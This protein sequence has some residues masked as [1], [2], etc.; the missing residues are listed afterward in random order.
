MGKKKFVQ[1]NHDADNP[2]GLSSSLVYTM[3]EDQEG[4]LWVGSD[5]LNR[6]DSETEKNTIFSYNPN[7]PNSLAGEHIYDLVE[8]KSG[9]IWIATATGDLPRK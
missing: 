5:R 2:D 8:D 6:L 4:D 9:I 7:D 1:F 3:I